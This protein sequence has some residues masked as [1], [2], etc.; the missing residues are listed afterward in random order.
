MFAIDLIV[1]TYNHAP[2]LD[3]M[4]AN[5]ARQR[6]PSDVEWRVLVV[7][8]RCT[9]ETP[10]VLRKHRAAG[11]IPELSVVGE[12]EQGLTPARRRGVEHTSAPWLAFVDDDCFLHDDWVEQAAAFA[13]AHPGCGAFGGRVTLEWE[14]TPPP[15]V[16]PFRYAFAEQDLGDQPREVPFIC[17]AGVVIRRSALMETGWL[18]RQLLA[19]RT[20]T[21]LISGGDV[22]LALR[23]G[24][25]HPLWYTPACHLRHLIPASRTTLEYLVAVNHGL[26]ASQAYA[27]AMLWPR[28][29]AAWWPAFTVRALR[30]GAR[31][32][33][34][35]LAARL[36][37]ASGEETKI[38]RSFLKGKWAGAAQ[39]ARMDPRRRRAL[40]G[41]GVPAPREPVA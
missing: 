35:A 4:L 37:R 3:R 26:G 25:L 24:A 32:S 20:G 11:Q 33:V 16:E 10:E 34:N 1:C 5:L 8:N 39:V 27:D 7:D 17:G 29:Y 41:C 9:D 15:F 22:E 21:R 23:I 13:R 18:D 6:A 19:D 38:A 36:G 14:S 2:M 31:F 30:D 40:F 12:P 28:S